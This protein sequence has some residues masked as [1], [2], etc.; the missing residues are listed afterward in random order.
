MRRLQDGGH[1]DRYVTWE[2]TGEAAVSRAGLDAFLED[3]PPG[4]LRLKG[5][6]SLT[7]GSTVV[8]QRV[9][10]RSTVEPHPTG[11]SDHECVLVAIGIRDVVDTG[12]LTRLADAHL[13]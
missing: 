7:D 9:G 8:V 4:V 10:G 2:W 13:S 11:P 1:T 5:F 6:I 3:L 12:T